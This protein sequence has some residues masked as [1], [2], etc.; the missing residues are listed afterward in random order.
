MTRVRTQISRN[1]FVELVEYYYVIREDRE[2][3]NPFLN[4]FAL[5]KNRQF[6]QHLIDCVNR[7]QVSLHNADSSDDI[8][9]NMLKEYDYEITMSARDGSLYAFDTL[10]LIDFTQTFMELMDEKGV[11]EIYENRVEDIEVGGYGRVTV[12]FE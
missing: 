4:L 9:V 3:L 5:L 2:G 6:I 1:H 10:D 7:Y 8:V 11:W 12:T